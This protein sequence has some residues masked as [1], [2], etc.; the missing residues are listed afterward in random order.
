MRVLVISRAMVASSYR[1]RLSAMAQLGVALT[2]VAPDKWERQKFEPGK[3]D[4]YEMIVVPAAACWPFLGDLA[5]HTFYF[6]GISRLIGRERWDLIHIDDEPYNFATFHA[7]AACISRNARFVF[8]TWQNMMK[9]YPPPFSRFE[10]KTFATAA[11]ATPG[12]SEA[13]AILRRRGFSGPAAVVPHHGVDVESFRRFDANSLRRKLGF[14]SSF[15]IGYVGRLVHRKGIHTLIRALAHLPAQ[16]SLVILGSGP[17]HSQLR[18]TGDELGIGDR[19]HWI[20][21]TATGEL[22]VYMNAFDVLVLPSLTT[23][24]WKEQFGRVLA[25][26]MACETCVVG[27]DS[28]E[29]PNVIGDAGLVFHESNETEL[30]DCLRRVLND[31]SLRQALG[32]RGRQRVVAN[33]SDRSVAQHLVSFYNRV[34]G[35][36]EPNITESAQAVAS[37]S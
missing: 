3:A 36:S 31:A 2:V 8:T 12:N 18:R 28:G 14:G 7:A 24:V 27:S 30:A 13:L 16:C 37:R 11:G 6:K 1:R 32:R 15:V 23:R 26:A 10:R 20:P 19:I 21:W 4:G 9:S 29:I 5:H 35:Q 17:F 33:F 22:P 34:C 25:E